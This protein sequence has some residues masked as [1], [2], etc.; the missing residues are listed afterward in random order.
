M[1]SKMPLYQQILFNE[2][3]RKKTTDMKPVSLKMIKIR[4]EDMIIP[5]LQQAKAAKWWYWF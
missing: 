1:K 3:R 4:Y 5:V 2:Y